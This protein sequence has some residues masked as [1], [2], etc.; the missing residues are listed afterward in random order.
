MALFEKNIS[1]L[2]AALAAVSDE[3]L[4][5]IWSMRK[6]DKVLFSLPRIAVLRSIFMNHLIH[7]RAQLGV[8]LRLLDIPVPAM[9]GPTA[10]E[11][12]M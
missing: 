11:G 5:T 1:N 7:H 2:R 10:D 3:Q 12:R 8:Y 9:Y 6:G 4:K